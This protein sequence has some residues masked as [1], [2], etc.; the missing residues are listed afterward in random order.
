M[1]A[2]IPF[3]AQYTFPFTTK[4]KDSCAGKQNIFISLKSVLS[5]SNGKPSL[6][7]GFFLYIFYLALNTH[8]LEGRGEEMHGVAFALID[9]NL[10]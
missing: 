2:Y 10:G 4:A 1:Q 3:Y 6:A 5:H 9:I 8:L 7:F